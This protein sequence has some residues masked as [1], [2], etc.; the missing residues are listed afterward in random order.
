MDVAAPV[1]GRGGVAVAAIELGLPDLRADL[2]MA[3]MALAVAT[4][5][6]S[7]ELMVDRAHFR[8][9]GLRLVPDPVSGAATPAAGS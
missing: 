5:S 6:L 2:D 7:R 9:A 8:Q 3:K 4:R 1:F